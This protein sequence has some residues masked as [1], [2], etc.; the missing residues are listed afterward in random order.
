MTLTV[1]TWDLVGVVA[2]CVPFAFPKDDL[3][4]LHGVRIEWDG[5]RLHALASDRYRVAWSQWHPDDDPPADTQADLFTKLGGNDGP[6]GVFLH[7]EDAKKLVQIYK[8][9]MKQS[10]APLTVD[11]DLNRITVTRA[12]ETGHAAIT[13]AF[14]GLEVEMPDLR[15]LLVNNAALTETDQI[16]YQPAYLA[17]FAKVR[18][19]GPLEMRFTG[20]SGL[21]HIA[22]GQRFVGAIMPVRL[23]EDAGG[24]GTGG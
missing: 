14:E 4:M 20:S 5:E 7:L 23:G 22:I 9:P 10:G 17:D 19:A 3:L 18:P 12:R 21:T 24:E 8:L 13:A 11:V 15:G 2:D 16:S 1:P 6:W